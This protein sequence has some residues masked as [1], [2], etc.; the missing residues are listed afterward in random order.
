LIAKNKVHKK[1]LSYLKNKEFKKIYNNFDK[2]LNERNINTFAVS[3]SGGSDSMAMAYFSKCHQILNNSKIYYVH[4]DHKLRKHSSNE[5]RELKYFMKKFDINCEI[6]NWKKNKNLRGTQENAR[7]ARYNL[8]ENFCKRKKITSLFL[9]HHI[10]DLYENFFIRMLRGSGIRGLTSF[11][12]KDTVISSNLKSYRPFLSLSKNLLLNVTKKV[13]GYFIKDPSNSNNEFLRIRIR[14]LLSNLQKDGF[15]KK[16]FNLT[17]CNLQSA[18]E[19]L[20]FYS[21]Q[22]ILKN[23]SFFKKK[24]KNS[25]VINSNFFM[26]PNEIVLRSFSSLISKI[27]KK[28]Y[29]SRGKT[30]IKKIKEIRLN[31]FKKATVGGCIVE[32]VNNTIIIYPENIK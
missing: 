8:L 2:F 5:A 21:N 1:I 13:F 22:N 15:D 14:S 3:L 32:R 7:I 9:A 24:N 27:N 31:S 25:V 4:I 28:Y 18:N 26:Q 16:K 23:T 12:S 10:D 11:S 20:K 30:L 29:F 6:L 19:T 17:Y